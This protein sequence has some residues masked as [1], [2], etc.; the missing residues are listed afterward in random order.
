MIDHIS[1]R[2]QQSRPAVVATV[3][4]VVGSTPQVVGCKA[5]IE[6]DGAIAGTLGGGM[7]EAEA[8]R[9]GA[10]ACAAG[11]LTV[12]EFSMDATYS[13]EA[14]PIC[15]GTMWV[16]LDARREMLLPAYEAASHA[17]AEKRS[18]LLVTP[19]DTDVPPR[20]IDAGEI[21]SGAGEIPVEDLRSALAC[22]TAICREGVPPIFIDPVIPAPRLL[23]VGGGHVGQAVAL[24]SQ[25]LGFDVTVVDDRPDFT[26]PDRF[27]PGIA[28]HH[29]IVYDMVR[30][31]GIDASTYVVLVSKGH[32]T[33]AEALEACIDSPAAYIGMIGSR[34]KVLEVKADF[35]RR[36]RTT[37]E[38]WTRVHA[39]IGLDIGA[40]T[41]PEIATSITAQLVAVRRKGTSPLPPFEG[42]QPRCASPLR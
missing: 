24:Q 15:G 14:G 10:E 9:R 26:Q 23:V 40:V 6:P 2:L 5:L 28:T 35:L 33:D 41:V 22:E 34:R 25:A 42:G 36:G 30:G 37:E 19:L 31:F 21:G 1:K 32:K 12:F 20:W 38:S 4:K 29:G 18:G 7:V 27:A 3:V 17:L 16:M 13:R 8:Q 11:G 39:P